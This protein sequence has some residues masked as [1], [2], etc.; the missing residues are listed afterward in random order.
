[1]ALEWQAGLPL[2]HHGPVQIYRC[3]DTPASRVTFGQGRKQALLLQRMPPSVNPLPRHLI[4][5]CNL[6]HRCTAHVNRQND[7]KLLLAAP[8][9]TALQPKNIPTHH[10]TR[11]KQVV[12][13]MP[14]TITLPSGRRCQPGCYT[15]PLVPPQTKSPSGLP[16]AVRKVRRRHGV[17]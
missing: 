8:T 15:S 10:K 16:L 11:I 3:S 1:M 12:M 2:R 17:I 7:L 9:T 6:R 13:H 5:L 14:Y 4:P